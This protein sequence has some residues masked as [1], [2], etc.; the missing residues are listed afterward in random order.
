MTQEEEWQQKKAQIAQ[1]LEGISNDTGT[2]RNIRRTAKNAADELDNSKL[3]PPVRA[4][5]AIEMINEILS[6][7]NMPSWTRTALW[8]AI[9]LLETVRR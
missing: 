2:P 8:S 1:I 5:N 3:S 6:D 7:P 4:A 9:S